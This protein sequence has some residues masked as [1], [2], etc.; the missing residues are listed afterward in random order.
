MT[1]AHPKGCAFVIVGE[2]GFEKG[3]KKTSQ[4]DV[5]SP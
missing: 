5:F 1:K 2:D 4:C 3:V